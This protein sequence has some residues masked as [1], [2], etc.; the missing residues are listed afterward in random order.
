MDREAWLATIHGVTKSQTRLKRIH[1][2]S[3][4]GNT[5][6]AVQTHTERASSVVE[7]MRW[8]MG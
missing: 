5:L 3:V 7:A 8:E 2:W 6:G 4:G 1:T